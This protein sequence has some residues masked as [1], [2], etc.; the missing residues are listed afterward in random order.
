MSFFSKNHV[1]KGRRVGSRSNSFTTIHHNNSPQLL[2]LSK[3]IALFDTTRIYF[4]I[5]LLLIRNPGDERISSHKW[6]VSTVLDSFFQKKKKI[7][8]LRSYH[9]FAISAK[10]H[11]TSLPQPSL[12]SHMLIFAHGVYKA[13]SIHHR[14][15][16]NKS[17]RRKFAPISHQRLYTNRQNVNT[18]Y[19][20]AR[21]VDCC[22]RNA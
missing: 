20:Y 9:Q 7:Q 13:Q 21:R 17:T 4:S 10:N 5:K 12:I 14:E 2:H 6:C 19:Q 16:S 3:T 1:P 11:S 15:T 22:K 8:L 18:K